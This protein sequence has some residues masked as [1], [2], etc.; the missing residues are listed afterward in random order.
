MSEGHETD[1][2]RSAEMARIA[3]R[4]LEDKKAEDIRMLDISEVSV[5]AD[6]FIIASG[7]NRNQLQA[8]KENVEEQMEKAG[9]FVKNVE[10]YDTAHWILMDYGD[11]ILHIFDEESRTFFDL[12][13]IWR[14]GRPVTPDAVADK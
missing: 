10:G 11:V 2:A 9:F 6:Y 7:K 4:A 8:L 13:R 1:K 12:E 14:D 3:T 5:L